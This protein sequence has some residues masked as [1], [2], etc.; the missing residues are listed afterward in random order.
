MGTRL[1]E[2]ELKGLRCDG[3][4]EAITI[5]AQGKALNSLLPMRGRR[6]E[7]RRLP[8]GGDIEADTEKRKNTDEYIQKGWW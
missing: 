6:K 3:D 2:P 7:Q 5:T 8:G 1:C 4:D